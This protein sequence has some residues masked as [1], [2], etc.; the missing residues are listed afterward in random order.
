M[1][2]QLWDRNLKV[3]SFSQIQDLQLQGQGPNYVSKVKEGDD[4]LSVT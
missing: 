1:V 2:F 3:S 4:F